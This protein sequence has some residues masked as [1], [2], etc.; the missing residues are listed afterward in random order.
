MKNNNLIEGLFSKRN[1]FEVALCCSYTLDLHFFE[2]YLMKQEAFSSC[3]N[4]TIFTDANTYDS[5]IDVSYRPRFLNKKYLVNRIIAAGVFHSKLYLFV[6]AKKVM[7]GVG[8]ANLSR[9]GIASNFEILSIFEITESDTQYSNLLL[10]CMHYFIK[11]AEISK[12]KKAIE[13]VEIVSNLCSKFYNKIESTNESIVF[14]NNINSSIFL[15][16]YSLLKDKTIENIKVISPFYDTK[17]SSL[18]ELKKLLPSTTIEIYIQQSKSNFPIRQYSNSSQQVKLF[19]FEKVERYLHG[20]ALIITTDDGIYLLTGS[21][22]FTYPALFSTIVNGNYEIGLFGKID[23]A[24]LK[25]LLNPEGKKPKQVTDFSK[26]KVVKEEIDE[27]KKNNLINDYIIDAVQINNKIEINTNREITIDVIKPKRIIIRDFN[28]N[29]ISISFSSNSF[30]VDNEIKKKTSGAISIQILG[31][32]KSGTEV[33]SNISWVINLEESTN[34]SYKRKLNQAFN[35]PFDLPSILIEILKH[36]N[37]DEIIL[38]LRTYD[39]P[40]DLILPPRNFKQGASRDSKGNLIGVL[41]SSQYSNFLTSNLR[42]VFQDFIDRQLNKLSQ[43]CENPQL[44]SV[45]NFFTIYYALF[46][47]IEFINVNSYIN[48]HAKSYFEVNEWK[49]IRVYYNLIFQYL[50]KGLDIL[51]GADSYRDSINEIINLEKNPDLDEDYSTSFEQIIGEYNQENLMKIFEVA[52]KSIE[53]YDYYESNILLKP[54]RGELVASKSFKNDS[55]INDRKKLD[56]KI[57][58]I[59]NAYIQALENIDVIVDEL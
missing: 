6:S 8:S 19:L 2:N 34:N 20:K 43:H 49:E 21:A 45:N 18:N 40:L 17:L 26:I 32:N 44:K 38:F 28:N 48:N 50:E 57:T 5:F 7:I 59:K 16:V 25:N 39:I 47:F 27:F 30:I 9:D 53:H 3:D 55:F 31:S 37:T 23:D 4:I 14:L 33:K 10:S 56:T 24:I 12:S 51:W 11:L 58:S 46:S 1:Q 54:E 13:R 15:S 35:N 42:V 22:N 52:T 29:E 41:D 36:G